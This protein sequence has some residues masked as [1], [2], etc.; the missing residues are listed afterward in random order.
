MT[1]GAG[2]VAPLPHLG[3]WLPPKEVAPKLGVSW[4]TVYR[5]IRSGDLK[6]RR[7]GRGRGTL[8]VE[9]SEITRYLDSAETAAA[10]DLLTAVPA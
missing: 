4:S 10:T 2:T 9:I 8:K 5:L 6:A 7:I 3:E 1:D